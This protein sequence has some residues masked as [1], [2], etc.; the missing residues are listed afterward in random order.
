[1]RVPL[2]SL[3]RTTAETDVPRNKKGQL[4]QQMKSRRECGRTYTEEAVLDSSPTEQLLVV[5]SVAFVVCI[6]R[7]C[8]LRPDDLTGVARDDDP[9]F[10]R[11]AFEES[12]ADLPQADVMVWCDVAAIIR[13][14]WCGSGAVIHWTGEQDH[15]SIATAAGRYGSPYRAEMIAILKAVEAKLSHSAIAVRIH[16]DSRQAAKQL[17]EG[18]ASQD[19]RIGCRIWE[20]LVA[21]TDSNTDNVVPLIWVP[22]HTGVEGN[23]WADKVAKEGGRRNESYA[24]VAMGSAFLYWR[25]FTVLSWAEEFAKTAQG[26]PTGT[27][28]CHS[29]CCNNSQ[30]SSRI[31][32]G[33]PRQAQIEIHQEAQ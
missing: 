11:R 15:E 8:H 18:P 31:P 4:R 1:M 27:A 2:D 21:I 12:C 19:E 30:L 33:V 28:D 17:A 16:L 14:A 24:A 6:T 10:R 32:P 13:T 29:K 25:L 3:L 22:G 26:K 20:K 23:E 5:L 9:V 7:K